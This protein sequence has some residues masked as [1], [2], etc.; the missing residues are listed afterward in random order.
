MPFRASGPAHRGETGEGWKVREEKKNKT[1]QI[2]PQGENRR[3]EEYEEKGKGRKGESVRKSQK[4]KQ[5]EKLKREKLKKPT[6]RK[7][8]LGR[9]QEQGQRRMKVHERLGQRHRAI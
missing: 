7:A 1:F 9:E 5:R 8:V 2:G 3:N 4:P 6:G